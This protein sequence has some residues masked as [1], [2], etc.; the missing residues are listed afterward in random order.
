MPGEGKG[1][2]EGGTR[3]RG[4]G[5]ECIENWNRKRAT[6]NNILLLLN[7]GY[8]LLKKKGRTSLLFS[9]IS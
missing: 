2:T 6:N 1:G 5:R 3:V 7:V 4:R 8:D 9:T